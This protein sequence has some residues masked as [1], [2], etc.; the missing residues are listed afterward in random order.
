MPIIP[1]ERFNITQYGAIGDGQATNTTAIQTAINAAEAAGGGIV[2]VPAGIFLS[3]PIQLAS[4]INLRVEKN[5]VLR[6]LPLGKY[7]GGTVDPAN[8]ISGASLHDVAISGS[9]TIDGQG[10]PWWPFAR[11][12]GAHRPRMIALNACDRC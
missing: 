3:G 7:P 5:A 8:F 10:I 12:H 2:E 11:I 9:G 4:R 1:G 6:M